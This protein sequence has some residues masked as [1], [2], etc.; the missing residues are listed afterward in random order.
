M[1]KLCVDVMLSVYEALVFANLGIRWN[2]SHSRTMTFHLSLRKRGFYRIKPIAAYGIE[3][4]EDRFDLKFLFSVQESD[5]LCPIKDEPQHQQWE[6]YFDVKSCKIEKLHFEIADKSGRG[7]AF[8]SLTVDE[9]DNLC[10]EDNCFSTKTVN[11]IPKGALILSVGYF[12]DIHAVNNMNGHGFGERINGVARRRGAVKHQNVHEAKGHKFIAK[13]FRQPTFCAFCKEFL[14]GFGKQGYQCQACQVAV[15]KKCHDKFLGKC[16]GSSM[17]SQATQYLRARFKIDMPHRF[18]VHTFRSP[19]FCNHCG[20]LLY[21]FR[22]QGLKCKQIENIFYQSDS[23]NFNE[24]SDLEC[25]EEFYNDPFSDKGEFQNKNDEEYIELESD[26]DSEIIPRRKRRS[27]RLS[28]S[29]SESS[30]EKLDE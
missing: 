1:A 17:Q 2:S 7:L 20:S 8:L 29:D 21:G 12:D 11:L 18:Q 10:P 30:H 13:F 16:T 26:N 25:D 4:F 9:I 5:S 14:W 22:K 27:R 19:T 15:H 28:S 3:D 6:S 23:D 24:S